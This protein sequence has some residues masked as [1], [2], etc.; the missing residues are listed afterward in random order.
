SSLRR[1]SPA[2]STKARRRTSTS[3]SSGSA[4]SWSCCSTSEARSAS[5]G[6]ACARPPPSS[7]SRWR[8]W[9]RRAR[10]AHSP[11]S[12]PRSPTMIS[13]TSS[14]IRPPRDDHELY[15]LLVPRD[16]L[17][18]RLL[19]ARPVREDDESSVHLQQDQP[20][21]EGQD[22]LARDRDRAHLVL[23]LPAAVARGNTRLQDPVPPLYGARSGLLRRQPQADPEGG[24]RRGLRR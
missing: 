2:S 18:D 9:S 12:S 13:T 3:R 7:P 23:R 19:R 16:Q 21:G 22:D 4:S 6:S 11:P 8:S 17:Q 10:A 14:T 1:N 15:Q 5:S 24:R 20:R